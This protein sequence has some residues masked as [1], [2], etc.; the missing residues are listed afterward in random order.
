MSD[1][2]L[3][4][5]LYVQLSD[6]AEL[7]DRVIVD[8]ELK[9][10]DDADQKQRERLAGLLRTLQH[11]PDSNFNTALLVTILKSRTTT[12]HKSWAEIAD[13]ITQ[14]NASTAVI[15]QL[16]VLAQA[17]ESERVDMHARIQGTHA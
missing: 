10:S 2:G 9:R 5:R 16:E 6:C 13:A 3:Y 4:T 8:L 12:Q 17:L 11:S 7:L 1:P 14:G 15:E